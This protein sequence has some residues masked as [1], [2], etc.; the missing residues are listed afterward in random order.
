MRDWRAPLR[1]W[2]AVA[3]FVGALR[4]EDGKG[5][6]RAAMLVAAGALLEGAGLMLLAPILLVVTDPTGQWSHSTL[7]AWL[8]AFLPA[9]PVSRLASLLGLFVAVMIVRGA[10]LH[11]RDTALA[12]LQTGFVEAQRS[13]VIRA[14]ADAP[15]PRVAGLRHARVSGLVGTE[16]QR[17]GSS[18]QY[19]IQGA[20]AL[21]MLGIQAGLALALSPG[22][23]AILLL[24]LGLGALALLFGQ[25][26]ARDLGIEVLTASQALMGSAA[27]LLAGLKTAAAQNAQDAF[28]GEFHATQ[29]HLRSR[30]LLFLKR[31][32]GTRLIFGIGSAVIGSAVLLVGFGVFGL[33]PALLIALLVIFARMAGP[34]QLV[35]Q[36]AQ[37][38]FFAVGSF[39][40][41]D[42]L[43]R[44]LDSDAQD[45]GQGIAAPLQGDIALRGVSFGH[46]GGGGVHGLDLS[47]REGEFVGIAGHSGAGKTT[48]ID[49]LA[50]LIV[51][52]AGEIRVGGVRLTPENAPG[53]QRGISYLAQDGF[54]FNDTL[55]RNLLWA[56]V[57]TGEEALARALAL[58]GAS[59]LV[60]RL[61]AGLDTV[62]GERGALF[63]GGERQRLALAR[64]LLRNPALL[65]LDEATSAID[66]AGEAALLARIGTLVPRPTIVMITHRDEGLRHCDRVITLKNGTLATLVAVPCDD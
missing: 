17:L 55:R 54:L 29:T 40:A 39:E 52:Q 23:S 61:P 22:F 27:S 31:Q 10:I 49:L 4:G 35:Q 41:I 33:A 18:V 48:L 32:A 51:P 62:V 1:P 56:A 9:A 38:F 7:F 57:E 13:R 50:G 8:G 45:G 19:L 24:V 46:A 44:E 25:R 37:N 28:V 64:A 3:H 36:A 21:A 58:A 16:I 63:S 34:A 14:L 66:T 11:A 42:A 65:I 43:V 53:W 47:I 60:A 5:T 2:R 20:V 15:W 6:A 30:Q 26:R 12:R 59:E